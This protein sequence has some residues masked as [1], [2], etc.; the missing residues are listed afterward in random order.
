MYAEC[1]LCSDG[2][3][4]IGDMG[5]F[6]NFSRHVA[7]KHEKELEIFVKSNKSDPKQ[8]SMSN[9]TIPLA[10]GKRKQSELEKII[11]KLIIHENISLN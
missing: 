5:S 7:R 2:K 1:K 10:I 9:F 4:Y 8:P 6:S 11:G 3:F